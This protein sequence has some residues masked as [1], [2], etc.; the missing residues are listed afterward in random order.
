MMRAA[1]VTVFLVILTAFSNASLAQTQSNS[2]S[3]TN[4]DVTELVKAGLS[5]EVIVAKIKNSGSTFDTSPAALR[6]LKDAGVPEAIILAMV[7][8]P[9]GGRND[10]PAISPD[11]STEKVGVKNL[12]EVRKIYIDEMGKSD[13]AERFRLLVGEKLSEKGFT[14]VEKPDDADAILKGALATQLSQGTTKARASVYLKSVSGQSLWN[15][16]YGVRFVFGPHRD[17]I[18]LRAEDVANGLHDAWKKSA[19]A[20]GIKTK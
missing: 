12:Y 10:T 7:Q 13:D 15:E 18:K 1:C 16:D 6:E 14:I 11:K 17:S 3:L 20:A 19:K 4:K 9:T 8:A 2:S 5:S